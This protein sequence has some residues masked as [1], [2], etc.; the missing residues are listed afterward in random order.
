M[1]VRAKSGMSMSA[2]IRAAPTKK[3]TSTA[4]HAGVRR[5]APRGTSGAAARRR[6]STRTAAATAAPRRYQRPWSEKTWTLGSAVAKAR[7]TPPSATASSAEPT[8]SASRA[9]R[10]QLRRSTSGR[11][12]V[13]QRTRSSANAA[14]ATSPTGVSHRLLPA[15]GM[16]SWP[17]VRSRISGGGWVK[18]SGAG[19][20]GQQQRARRPPG[21]A[22]AVARVDRGRAGALRPDRGRQ[23]QAD[24]EVDR[25]DAPPVG[26]RQH[27]GAEQRAEHAAELL[28]GRDDAERYAAALD[29]VEVGHQRE[30]GRDQPAA[31]DALE[32]PARDHARHVVGQRGHQRPDGEEHQ[33][34]HQH[35][36]PPAQVGD[37]PDHREHRD[38]A[39]QEAGHDRGGPLELVDRD[40]D[41]AHHLRQREH[42]DVGVGRGEGDRDGGQPEQQP[43][44]PRPGRARSRRPRRRVMAP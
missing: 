18:T 44:R 3:L 20:E 1:V 42:H 21:R 5:S 2:A 25:E 35:R 15:T 31:A 40:A 8:R 29:G 14:S 17:Q 43:G 30:R 33:R 36:D 7:I 24:H 12:A 6:W 37:P 13:T 32:E 19:H 39:E 16:N 41:R 10:P 28:H 26:D 22:V 34:R 38:V 27:H 9:A 11:A 4:P 23:H